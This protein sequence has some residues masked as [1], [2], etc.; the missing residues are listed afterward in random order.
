MNTAELIKQL[1]EFTQAGMKDCI[2]ALKESGNDLEKAID[3]IKVKGKNIVSGRSGRIASEGLV[4]IRSLPYTNA[5]AMLEVNCQT[6]FVAR[7]EQFQS[8][9][10]IAMQGLVVAVTNN[11]TWD[12]KDNITTAA[13]ENVTSSTKENIV[14]RRWW[15]EE[16]IDPTAKVFH[17]LHNGDQLGVILTL[18]APSVEAASDPRFIALGNDL[19]MQVAAMSPVA[20]SAEHV[21]PEVKERQQA[22]FETQLKEANKPET[23]WAKIL[24]G[25]FNKWYS[26]S[27]LLEQESVLHPKSSVK[28]VIAL[29]S[30]QIGGDIT[31]ANMIRCQVGEGIVKEKIG[32]ADEVAKLM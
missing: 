4:V 24:T 22:I 13:I 23:A 26:E 31:V 9:A 2:D 21:L 29:V 7:S 28:D 32:L 12:G 11:Q 19:A 6:D 3:I 14:V 16:V 1:R 30:K 15:V 8:L 25:K 20:I 27:C 17:Y 5:I 18:Q 10:N